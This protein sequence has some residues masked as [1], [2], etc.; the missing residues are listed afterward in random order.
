MKARCVICGNPVVS[1][2]SYWELSES[3]ATELGVP[4]WSKIWYTLC[5]R[6]VI[7]ETTAETVEKIIARDYKENKS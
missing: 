3:Q 1:I 2:L 6:H 4:R 5:D 7:N